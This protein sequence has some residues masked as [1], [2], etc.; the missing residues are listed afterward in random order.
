[1][2]NMMTVSLN[3]IVKDEVDEVTALVNKAEGYFDG[4]FITVSDQQ[5]HQKLK[6]IQ[7]DKIKVDFRVWNNRFDDARNHNWDLAKDF[8]ASFW[9]DADDKFEFYQ[10]PVLVK[11]LE[12]YDAVFLPYHYDHDEDGNLIVSHW[13]ERLVKRAKG[14]YWKGWVH[15]NLISDQPFTKTNAPFPVVHNQKEG[16]KESS[17][18]RNHEILMEA[19]QETKD[20]R[21]IHYLGIS[22]FTLHRF[23]EAI[24]VL[25]EYIGVGG[26]DEEI[27]RSL[28][29]MA[30]ASH[31]LD[32]YQD[33]VQYAIRA[34]ALMPH[35]PMA[36]EVLAHFEFQSKNYKEALEWVKMSL[37][38]PYPE[39]ASIF[40]PTSKD[41][42]ILTGALC[43]YQLGNYID[44][45]RLIKKVKTVDVSDLYDEF[46]REASIE[47]LHA[48]LPIL[49]KHFEDPSKL[50]GLLKEDIKYRPKFRQ[51]REASTEPKTWDK[52]TIVIFCGKGYEEWGPHT[53][54][55]GMGGSEEA[56]VYLAPQLVKLGY[57]VTV[58]GELETPLIADNVQWLP[59]SYIDKRDKF[60]TLIVW[61]QPQF[62]T[63][64]TA[65]R[66][67]I[68]M[69]DLLP[70]A[71]VK[72]IKNAHYMF[73]S[74]WHKDQY[75]DIKDFS[76]VP[77]GIEV[78]QFSTKEKKPHSV[79]YPSAYYRGL[80]KLLNIWP[81][82]RKEIPDATL[83]IYYG[84]ES[85]VTAEGRDDFYHRTIK[86][87]DELK[88][89]GVTEHGRVDHQT[90]A[91]KY[92]ESKVWAYPTEFPEIFCITAVKANLAGCKP[93]ITD[94]A[95]LTETGGPSADY[96][97]TD[98]I[99]G[100]E[101]KS[102]QFT[103]KLIKALKEDHDPTEQIE[104]AKKFGWSNVAQSWN[105]VIKEA[106]DA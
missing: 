65:K 84:W 10:I 81:N 1:M 96:V 41:R 67:L 50:W 28:I 71:V 83:D 55:K 85:W 91:D 46:D 79:I 29:K 49:A 39:T 34:I 2:E 33:S 11:L 78:S 92:A 18:Q 25:K 30:E 52:N 60:D 88:D 21:Y 22:L 100:D 70:T 4:I 98:H 51:I 68:D 17:S 86:L 75:P 76:I 7:N 40:D 58:Y 9:I 37:Q 62:A 90:L 32:K 3:M 6:K 74:Q 89:Q 19:Y 66:L 16:H 5:A 106:I 24:E 94:V 48:V 102:E 12:E 31:M 26:W 8:D 56:I 42:A 15:E 103:K 80:E 82:V 36:Y 93:V 105:K 53:L 35:Y 101:Y 54:S 38:K 57:K 14:F 20:P 73:K 43:E 87:L 23:E 13:R 69:H 104:W 63:Q 64:F 45:S 44:A 27:Y 72:P 61:R 99:Y 95:A 77:N 59:W 47:Q 97:E